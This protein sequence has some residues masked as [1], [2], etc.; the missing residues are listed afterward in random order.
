M[1]DA[2]ICAV[3]K[4]AGPG[5]VAAGE[6]GSSRRIAERELAVIAIKPYARLRERI[7][8]G[9]LRAEAA[10]VAADLHAHIVRH[11]KQHV[12]LARWLGSI[13]AQRTGERSNR[14]QT[15][16]A[17]QKLPAR[18]TTFIREA[19][20]FSLEYVRDLAR[21]ILTGLTGLTGF[22]CRNNCE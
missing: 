20:A 4:H 11:D 19:H 14:G 7:E 5:R 9:G 21:R 22:I 12:R 17:A 18:P 8:I 16:H 15:G 2:K 13:R 3:A 6:Q 10:S 1:R